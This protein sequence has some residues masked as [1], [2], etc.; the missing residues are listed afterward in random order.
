M[1][2][3]LHRASARPSVLTQTKPCKRG[4]F[5]SPAVRGHQG[6]SRPGATRGG[7]AVDA[8]IYHIFHLRY[9]I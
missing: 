8:R 9:Q 3:S 6:S 7:A 2:H 4:G 5:I 1:L